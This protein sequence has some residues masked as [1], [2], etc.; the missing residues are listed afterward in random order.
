MNTAM[1]SPTAYHGGEYSATIEEVIERIQSY[2]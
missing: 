2:L 1:F